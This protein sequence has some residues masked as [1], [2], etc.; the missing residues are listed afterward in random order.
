MRVC[1]TTKI[2]LVLSSICLI[3]PHTPIFSIL[4]FFSHIADALSRL[5]R[6]IKWE[7]GKLAATEER[8]KRSLQAKD[9]DEEEPNT[10][11]KS[12]QNGVDF[13]ENTVKEDLIAQAKKSRIEPAAFQPS[14]NNVDPAFVTTMDNLCKKF[15][16][17]DFELRKVL[18]SGGHG[19]K[20]RSS[21][22]PRHYSSAGR[23]RNHAPRDSPTKVDED[24]LLMIKKKIEAESYKCNGANL[25]ELFERIDEDGGGTIELDEFYKHLRRIV[26]NLSEHEVYQPLILHLSSLILY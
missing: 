3:C 18:R 10:T 22:P 16:L 1:M 23:S 26:P 4:S 5:D 11:S 19:E 12:K 17:E 24:K 6:E 13:A 20:N 15:A 25:V 14:P 7:Q 8:L 9:N 21:S 2:V